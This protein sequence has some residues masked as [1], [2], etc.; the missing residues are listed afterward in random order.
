MD[1]QLSEHL[2]SLGLPDDARAWVMDLWRVIQCLDDAQDGHKNEGAAD[3]AFAVFVRMPMNAFWQ[4]NAA[5]LMSALVLSIIKWR[6]ANE[7]EA[8][9]QADERSFMWRA[10]FY[11]VLALV[12]HICGGPAV[13]AL[14]LYGET[15][16]DYR[17]EFPCPI[18]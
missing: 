16:A 8:S 13:E 17:K 18:R 7:A 11:D 5:A 9:G 1:A 12:T 4:A 3:A 6:A 10:G 15:F 14:R 2:E